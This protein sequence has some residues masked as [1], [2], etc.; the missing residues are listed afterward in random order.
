MGTCARAVMIYEKRIGPRPRRHE[1]ARARYDLRRADSQA[2]RPD[3]HLITRIQVVFFSTQNSGQAYRQNGTKVLRV[4]ATTGQIKKSVTAPMLQCSIGRQRQ[5]CRIHRRLDRSRP[6]SADNCCSVLCSCPAAKSTVRDGA[7][8]LTLSYAPSLSPVVCP[9]LFGLPL[10]LMHVQDC[11][12][13]APGLRCQLI[14]LTRVCSRV[15]S[16]A[17]MSLF[18]RSRGMHVGQSRLIGEPV[19]HPTLTTL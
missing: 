10:S 3:D 14:L 16:I 7:R 12:G 1:L 6:L 2:R 11:V 18:R 19:L 5:R 4:L 8:R 13:G 9:R 17:A 15:I